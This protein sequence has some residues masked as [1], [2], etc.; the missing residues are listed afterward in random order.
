VRVNTECAAICGH[1][2]VCLVKCVTVFSLLSVQTV[3][4]FVSTGVCVVY[5]CVCVLKSATV[6]SLLSGMDGLQQ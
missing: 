3:L 6:L 5:V 2:C 1:E 4:Q